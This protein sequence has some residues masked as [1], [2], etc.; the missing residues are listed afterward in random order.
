MT[1]VGRMILPGCLLAL[2]LPLGGAGSGAGSTAATARNFPNLLFD[3][4]HLDR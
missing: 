1:G 3:A 4:P 2:I